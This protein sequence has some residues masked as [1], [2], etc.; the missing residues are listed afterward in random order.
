[1][2]SRSGSVV[3][4]AAVLSILFITPSAG[5]AACPV[6]IPGDFDCDSDVDFADQSEWTAC[7]SGPAI[8][9]TA[10]CL[11]LDTDWDSD[12]DMADY[13]V[14]QR[15]F[16]GPDQQ[17][18]LHCAGE[19]V[20][21]QDG[22]L[23]VIGTGANESLG[24]LLKAGLPAILEVDWGDDG[25]PEYQF[26]RSLFTHIEMYVGG[27]NDVVTIHET[28][29]IFTDTE[30]TMVDGGDDNDTFFSGSGGETFAGG[31][32]NDTG[33]LGVGNDR[34]VWNPGDDTDFVEGG[35]GIDTVEVN[36]GNGAE[37]FTTTANGLR[38]RFD[39][40]SPA[41]FF[42]DIGT[43]EKLVL[44][45][46]G[47]NDSFSATGNL[48]VLIQLTV[49]GGAGDD[50][51]LGSNGIDLLLGGDNN[52]FL[53][54]QQGNDVAF[55][56]AG[57]DTFQWDP[58]DGSDTVEGQAGADKLV[59][60]GSGIGEAM[61]AAANGGRV[62]FTRN[63]GTI[64]MDLDDLERID[65]NAVGGADTVTVGDLNGTDTTEVH[66]NLAGT[67]GG[68]AGDAQPDNVIVTGTNSIDTINITGSGTSA[69]VTG[70]SAQVNISIA[71]AA[72]DRITINALG[73]NDTLQANGLPAGIIGLTLNG[74]AGD[75]TLLGSGGTDVLNGDADNDMLIGGDGDDIAQMGLGND[76]FVW[77]P[78]D[79]T[80]LVE[81]GD[82]S[83]TVEVNGGNGAEAFT[84][85]ANGARV[86]FD[87]LD[88]APFALDIGTCENLVL[89]ANGGND[90]LACTGD[91]ASL[92]KITADGGAGDD[93]LLGSNGI[94]LLLGGDNNDFIDGQQGNDV[95]FLG[96]GDDT[97]QW[98]PG[99]GS[100]TV[101][102]Q[103]GADTLLFNGSS[104]NEIMQVSAN[105]GRVLFTRDIGNIVMDLDDVERIDIRA[106]LGTDTVTVNDLAGT[107][108]TQ[109]NA[110]LA[111]A[112][113]GGSGDAQADNVIV[114]GTN[115]IDTISITGTGTSVNV[116]GLSAVVNISVAEAAN[117]R[118][119]INALGANDNI[120]ANGLP[121]SIIG[122]TLNGGA[123]DD[124]LLGSGGTDVLNGD[125]DNDTLIG[126][127]GDDTAQMGLGND[128]FVWNPGDD[129]DFL[130]GGDGSDTVEVNGGNGD[131]AFTTTANGTRV[132][133]DR[134]SPAPF[135]L[136][137]GT[138]EKL[139]LNANG[140]ND[141]LSCTGNLAPLI[142]ITADGGAGDDT[143]LGSNG[144]DLLLG[145]DNNDFI[146]GQQGN[147]VAFLG[148]GDDT[149]QWD[150]GDGS[151]TVEG[152]AGADKLIFNG[153][154]IGEAMEASANGGRVRLTRNVGTIT[155]DL[156]DVER[157]D[158][159]AVGGADTA[160]V[161][162]LT[163]TDTTEVNVLL[164][165]AIGGGTGDAQADNVIVNGTAAADTIGIT[166]AGGIVQVAGLAATVRIT[167]PEPANDRLTVNGLG[168]VDTITTGPG[169]TTLIMLTTNQ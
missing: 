46:N 60:N 2:V 90:T 129:T 47:G 86:R 52:D 88:P 113:G 77:S 165:S 5:L 81:G 160:T 70:L 108:A 45:A 153:S 19:S 66:V 116:A 48:A 125:D 36:G 49:D 79:D 110:L 68:A 107:D 130:E 126:G 96:A 32:G 6:P 85:T 11:S 132:R 10:A 26:E 94:D 58:G 65:V 31:S 12:V 16:S 157:I 151:D 87:R 158:V 73:G 142:Q 131:E 128:R 53:D 99:D 8:A 74:G 1:M 140:G 27:G 93:S 119:T 54:G 17:A 15:C 120:Q 9:A 50:T 21:V 72:N 121:A 105:G 7:A 145:G 75:D 13:A 166:A 144:I 101:E 117:D 133:F 76:R 40:I 169:V 164:A 64:T 91:L 55:L 103:A 122:L 115:A 167:T 97:F 25:S 104:A 149:F 84:T 111:S 14:F 29:G 162:D 159:N 163:G 161:N 147:D 98:D 37:V 61:E 134:I 156:D 24:L 20:R 28:N 39:R 139:V 78:G 137:I 152:Q 3:F 22:R 18:D 124:T 100:D 62:R 33:F 23:I 41:P 82:G 138:C 63:V 35:D 4:V 154:G 34:F 95:A 30:I 102:G 56:G 150:P 168:G 43:C 148:A 141:T 67:L 123:G 114:N 51:L 106:L 136:D 146:D 80:D 44:N 118:L 112:I 92:I 143:L 59:F 57:D 109:V 69:S 127:D 83:D 89:N 38:V 135:F 155:M 42:L 71:E